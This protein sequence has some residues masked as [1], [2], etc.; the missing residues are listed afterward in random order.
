MLA[1]QQ[2]LH[3][4]FITAN[5]SPLLEMCQQAK[6]YSSVSVTSTIAGYNQVYLSV[7]K[8]ESLYFLI[9]KSIPSSAFCAVNAHMCTYL[10]LFTHVYITFLQE[11]KHIRFHQDLF[12]LPA[13]QEENHLFFC[14]ISVSRTHMSVYNR[15]AYLYA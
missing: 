5:F 14:R 3:F 1:S 2:C 9:F 8:D 4:L 10:Y 13:R 7:F 12:L 11:Q 15:S 6:I